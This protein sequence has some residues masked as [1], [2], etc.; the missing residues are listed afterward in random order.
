MKMSYVNAE[1]E[2]VLFDN[3]DVIATSSPTSNGLITGGVGSG[4]SGRFED[5]FP[6]LT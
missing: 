2:I 1:M 5:L 3:E 6:G 4:D